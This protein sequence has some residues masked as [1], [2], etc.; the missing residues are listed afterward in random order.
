M[1]ILR[2]PGHNLEIAVGDTLGSR[3][4]HT[5]FKAIGKWK[6]EWAGRMGGRE[7]KYGMQEICG[8]EANQHLY[9]TDSL[10]STLQTHSEV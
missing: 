3:S 5:E 2:Q 8:W 7:G 1:Y 9:T 6:R 10:I 4:C